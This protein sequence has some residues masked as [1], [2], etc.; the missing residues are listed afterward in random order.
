MTALGAQNVHVSTAGSRKR[1]E[2]AV[3][4]EEYGQ[5]GGIGLPSPHYTGAV[6]E[7]P[8]KARIRAKG[9]LDIAAN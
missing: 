7:F 8:E 9:Q 5:C 1:D 4:L 6:I 2:Q 3:L